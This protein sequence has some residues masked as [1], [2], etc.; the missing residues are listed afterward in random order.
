MRVAVPITPYLAHR[1]F[2]PELIRE[3]SAAFVAACAGL[4][5]QPTDD[6]ATRLVAEKVIELAQRGFHTA[7]ALRRATLAEF[8]VD[9]EQSGGQ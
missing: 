1:A 5:L 9:D 8:G 2:E 3:M 4:R 6:A 7:E